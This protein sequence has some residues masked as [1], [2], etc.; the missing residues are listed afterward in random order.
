MN[1]IR[2]ARMAVLGLM[3]CA[4][5]GLLTPVP[6][7]GAKTRTSVFDRCVSVPV[8]I[9][10]GPA[11]ST[12]P[13]PAASLAIPVTLPRFRGKPQSGVVTAV[14]SVGIRISHTDAG[15]LA[16]FLVSPGGRAIALA[17][18][19]DDSSNDSGDGYGTGATSCSGS[20]VQFGD[21]FSRPITMPGNTG[22]SAPIAGSFRPEQA[23]STFV[24]GPARGY[25]TLIVQDVASPDIGQINALSLN[26]TYRYKAKRKRKK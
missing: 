11:G 26:I 20:F 10:D 22:A 2:A 18:Y 21:G 16:L 14:N 5:V 8:G 25:W 1:K 24:G 4:A 17:T 12:D 7:A 19:R 9:P 3:G 23:L 15:D 13:N 6:S